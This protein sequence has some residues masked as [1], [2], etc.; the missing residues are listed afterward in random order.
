MVKIMWVDFDEN[1]ELLCFCDGDKECPDELKPP[2]SKYVVKFVPVSDSADSDLMS[3]D[4]LK[5]D[6]ENAM[7]TYYRNINKFKSTLEKSIRK[8]KV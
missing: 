6:M 7:T 5:K 4:D 1:L 2:C 3:I 8:F